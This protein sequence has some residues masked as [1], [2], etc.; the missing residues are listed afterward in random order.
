MDLGASKNMV[1]TTAV[2]IAC[3][4]LVIKQGIAVS[5]S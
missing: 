3:I 4:N 1:Q 2:L 5:Q